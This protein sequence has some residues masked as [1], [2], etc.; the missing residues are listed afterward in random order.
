MKNILFTA[1]LFGCVFFFVAESLGLLYSIVT[2]ITYYD[3]M[4]CVQFITDCLYY[5][6]MTVGGV[7]VGISAIYSLLTRRGA[8]AIWRYL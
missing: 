5:M 1:I 2:S 6:A 3:L 4:Y 8:D 7:A